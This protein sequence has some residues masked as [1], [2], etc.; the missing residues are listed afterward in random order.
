MRSLCCLAMLFALSACLSP[1]NSEPG[2]VGLEA[3]LTQAIAQ[4]NDDIEITQPTEKKQ[5]F[6]FLRRKPQADPA[7]ESDADIVL[8]IE[9]VEVSET[10]QKQRGLAALF[11][12]RQARIEP[13]PEDE[14]ITAALEI[15]D[16]ESKPAFGLFAFL[17]PGNRAKTSRAALLSEPENAK[18]PAGLGLFANGSNSPETDAISDAPL[19]FG[20]VG[21][22]CGIK[23]QNMGKQVDKTPKKGRA[24]FKLFDTEPGSI[25][26]RTQYITGFADGC[27]R[28]FIASLVLFGA[29]D[30]HE[31]HR[32][33]S[34]L[35]SVPYSG[36][37]NAYEKIKLSMC[38]VG[39]GKPCPDA[40]A[41]KLAKTTSFVTV[42]PTFGGNA[43]HLEILLH[44]GRLIASGV[45]N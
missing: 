22:A 2:E 42:Y 18:E 30:L 29:P 21:V 27:A 40:R 5:L 17:K 14:T 44:N 12:P 11:K 43:D 7:S 28:R 31:T 33:S 6:G 24:L 3:S 8:L 36:T 19:K 39:R 25:Q 9:N 38:G 20:E 35:K 23:R 32:Y 45:Q 37:D 34:A 15:Q 16:S 10:P 26:Q 13:A 1:Q 41:R 4:A